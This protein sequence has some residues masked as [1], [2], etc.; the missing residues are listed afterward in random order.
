MKTALHK[1]LLAGLMLLLV[2]K[3]AGCATGGAAPGVS[4]G[5]S[6]GTDG[7]RILEDVGRSSGAWA[8]NPCPWRPLN[9]SLDRDLATG[10]NPG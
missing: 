2:L 7:P 9:I 6:P 4:P 3:V 5:T 10:G 8:E 1:L